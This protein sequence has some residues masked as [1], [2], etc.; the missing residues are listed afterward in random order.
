[1]NITCPVAIAALSL[2]PHTSVIC[3]TSH[4]RLYLTATC[5][6]TRCFPGFL[7]QQKSNTSTLQVLLIL[8]F[9]SVKEP[10]AGERWFQLFPELL[11]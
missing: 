5:L 3:S 11:S 1:M 9:D 10:E 7:V 2:F 8:V 4:L 6:L